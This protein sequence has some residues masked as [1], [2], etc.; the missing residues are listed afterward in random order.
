M[1]SIA[2]YV[3]SLK[4]VDIAEGFRNAYNTEEQA[5]LRLSAA[6][7]PV[8]LMERSGM[9]RGTG[10]LVGRGDV[11]LI[12]IGGQHIGALCTGQGIAARL[13]RGVIELDLRF[14]HI[15]EVWSCR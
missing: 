6:G 2:D 8:T 12:E 4:G 1:L 9:P 13:E 7:G 5:F 3:Q 11:V 10:A 14:V 15:V